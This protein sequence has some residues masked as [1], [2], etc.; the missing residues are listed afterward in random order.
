MRYSIRDG[1]IF[2]VIGKVLGG[3]GDS[4]S[5]LAASL[6]SRASLDHITSILS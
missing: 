6:P 3:T 4:E 5:I 1:K 2:I